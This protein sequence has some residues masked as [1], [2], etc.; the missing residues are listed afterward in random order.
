MAEIIR[1][2]HGTIQGEVNPVNG[3]LVSLIFNGIEYFHDGGKSSFNGLGWGNSEI[4]PYPIFGPA[5]NQEV[6]VDYK[7]FSLEQHG[8][9]R[10]TNENP[11]VPQVQEKSNILTLVQKYSGQ[12][13]SNPKYESGNGRPEHLNW[14]PYTLEKTFELTDKGLICKLTVT[15][16]SE[17]NMPYMIGW[18]PA[19]KVQ[20]TVEEGEFVDDRGIKIATLADVIKYSNIPP[21]EALTKE[22]MNSI[23][24]RNKNTGQGV[25]VSS[26]NFSN[27]VML[28]SPSYDA[29]MLCI[30]H[31]S[32][33]PIFNG[34]KHFADLDRFESL[35]PGQ[36][37][38]YSILVQPLK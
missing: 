29:G 1:F 26:E 18:H 14:L 21:Q 32:R 8:I 9:S 27:N 13:I 23:T 25:R 35:A 3:Q 16:N 34:E 28:W 20:G 10:H 19:F 33:L 37:R 7:T 5:D 22:R 6:K 2:G 31:T 36:S 17:I 15:N 4:V 12:D 30:E 11:F 38:T 24:Y